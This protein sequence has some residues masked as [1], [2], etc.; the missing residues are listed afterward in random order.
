[1]T[2]FARRAYAYIC[3]EYG[4]TVEELQGR[5]RTYRV[6]HPR[7]LLMLILHR[8]GLS[9]PVTGRA[10]GNRD[11]TTVL[12][13]VRVVEKRDPELFA[14]S[15]DIAASL[16]ELAADDV[17]ARRDDYLSGVS[18][19]QGNY[20]R[21]AGNFPSERVSHRPAIVRVKQDNIAAHMHRVRFVAQWVADGGTP[22]EALS[23]HGLSDHEIGQYLRRYLP[24]LLGKVGY[25]R[26]RAAGE[27]LPRIELGERLARVAA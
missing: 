15:V 19:L 2:P 17:A 18:E 21:A 20:V 11:H 5:G 24:T 25:A 3:D 7:Q 26:S 13:A 14:A 23:P 16:R 22:K 1:M 27:C 12:H 10:V 9:M 4:L 6:A 8:G